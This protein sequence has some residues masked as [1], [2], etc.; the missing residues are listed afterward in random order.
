M[1]KQKKGSK[2]SAEK[3]NVHIEEAIASFNYTG[4]VGL[5]SN[6]K[7]YN[8]DEVFPERNDPRYEVRAAGKNGT[9]VYTHNLHGSAYLYAPSSKPNAKYAQNLTLKETVPAGKVICINRVLAMEPIHA[10]TESVKPYGVILNN[11]KN[12]TSKMNEVSVTEAGIF[13]G[14][15][16]ANYIAKELCKE[17]VTDAERM[18][19]YKLLSPTM[20][21][22]L[23]ACL[24]VDITEMEGQIMQMDKDGRI[25]RTG[26]SPIGVRNSEGQVA[27]IP[28]AEFTDLEQ[29]IDTARPYAI[30]MVSP[31]G[32]TIDEMVNFEGCPEPTLVVGGR[33]L[34]ATT[35]RR[36]SVVQV[37][38]EK[39]DMVV[40]LPIYQNS[41]FSE[42][43]SALGSTPDEIIISLM[44][45]CEK[46]NVPVTDIDYK[47][48]NID[49]LVLQQQKKVVKEIL[50]LG[51]VDAIIDA[52]DFHQI[53]AV[54]IEFINSSKGLTIKL[55]NDFLKFVS[56]DARGDLQVKGL[57]A[58]ATEI[59]KA[60]SN[61]N[62][63]LRLIKS[64]PAFFTMDQ[65]IHTTNTLFKYIGSKL[66]WE[67]AQAAPQNSRRVNEASTS[68]ASF[69]EKLDIKI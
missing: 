42:P 31:S 36:S 62:D 69:F 33:F 14:I 61:E 30:S 45:F 8:A 53:G 44:E 25:C 47:G 1:S 67:T 43:F 38:D 3:R 32:D 4:T 9:N 58:K 46:H 5:G 65:K 39:G 6:F 60:V 64:Y 21:A 13:T 68:L 54:N 28:Y 57:S 48:L 11:I 22:Y 19:L 24:S 29:F 37:M 16:A 56:I 66:T 52:D 20:I 18:E 34:N 50:D 12:L 59:Y 51:G 7:V 17:G 2:P 23:D 40:S 63:V 55:S 27:Y 49:E 41:V 10:A 26:G 35:T 15:R